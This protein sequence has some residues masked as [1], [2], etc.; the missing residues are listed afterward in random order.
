MSLNSVIHA[1]CQTLT[2]LADQLTHLPPGIYDKA[3]PLTDSGIGG[4]VRHI[5]EHYQELA[6]GLEEQHICYD[7]RV[8]NQLLEHSLKDAIETLRNLSAW[9]LTLA[10]QENI[11]LKL[12]AATSGSRQD[13]STTTESSLIRELLF[14][15]SH[16]VH[17]EAI[18]AML[19]KAQSID[20]PG[21]FGV[22][23]ATLQYREEIAIT[24]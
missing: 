18:I 13:A 8:R 20:V 3:T 9:L 19:M 2:A 23:P 7:K 24:S 10:G 1:N 12:T 15:Q 21:E 22:A 17:H 14:L 11:S 4:H 16:T 6:S 5:V